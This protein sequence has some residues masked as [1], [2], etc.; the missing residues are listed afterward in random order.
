MMAQQQLLQHYQELEYFYVYVAESEYSE[1]GYWILLEPDKTLSLKSLRGYYATC[2]GMK[3]KCIN[4]MNEVETKYVRYRNGF[5][6]FPAGI[7]MNNTR[8]IAYYYSDVDD[9]KGFMA[10]IEANDEGNATVPALDV[11]GCNLESNESAL[12]RTFMNF[13]M[14]NVL[15]RG[16]QSTPKSF[17]RKMPTLENVSS[18]SDVILN[19]PTIECITVP[20]S[21]SIIRNPPLPPPGPPYS[22]SYMKNNSPITLMPVGSSTSAKCKSGP[23]VSSTSNL[24]NENNEKCIRN[25][26]NR[27]NADETREFPPS[28]QNSI[29]VKAESMS[30]SK[31]ILNKYQQMH[32]KPFNVDQKTPLKI[33]LESRGRQE[34][35]KILKIEDNK[36]RTTALLTKK[37]WPG[38]IGTAKRR[39]D[40]IDEYETERIDKRRRYNTVQAQNYRQTEP[41]VLPSRND[42][43]RTMNVL[44]V[45]FHGT[46][47]FVDET[48]VYFREFGD[49]M[50][51]QLYTTDNRRDPPVHYA[52]MKICTNDAVALLSDRHLY[53]ESVIYA[54]RVDE[55]RLPSRL[56]CTVCGY[57][58]LNVG[59]LHYHL[60][61]QCHQSYLQKLVETIGKVYRQSYYRISYDKFYVQHPDVA[62]EAV[63]HEYWRRSRNSSIY[64]PAVFAPVNRHYKTERGRD[65]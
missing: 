21:S 46:A 27:I 48:T 9:V 47:P 61:G 63:R 13:D 32:S 49:V 52:F 15:K 25:K 28:K 20:D 29:R 58:G 23:N 36:G 18:T 55:S 16:A 44:L 12:G 51:F 17:S 38:K 56:T 4:P 59:H 31:N 7:D 10:L 34:N 37:N 64:S 65:Y 19:E 43:Y 41:K 24:E 54:I 22:K 60:E 33:T 26:Q 8:F 42:H 3:Y 50:D 53:N 6:R 45:G 1:I 57:Q 62:H 35:R 30:R 39:L 14:E 5:Y 2:F 40:R 11:R